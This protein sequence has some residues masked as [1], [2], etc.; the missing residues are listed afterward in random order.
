[1][2][3]LEKENGTLYEITFG[4]FTVHS[5]FKHM[6]IFRFMCARAIVRKEPLHS[7]LESHV[8]CVFYLCMGA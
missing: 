5:M 3:C 2:C 1:M 8:T 7:R 6:Y 4:V